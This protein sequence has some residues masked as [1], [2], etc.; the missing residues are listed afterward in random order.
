MIRAV[1]LAAGF[2]LLNVAPALRDM[3][4]AVAAQDNT[5]PAPPPHLAAVKAKPAPAPDYAHAPAMDGD[6]AQLSAVRDVRR[7]PE[8]RILSAAIDAQELPDEPASAPVELPV[9]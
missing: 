6:F 8:G 3:T 2:V 7:D 1:V 5:A 4:D 9:S